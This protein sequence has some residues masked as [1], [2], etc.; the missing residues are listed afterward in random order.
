MTTPLIIVT[1]STRLSIILLVIVSLGCAGEAQTRRKSPQASP[2]PTPTPNQLLDELTRPDP[3][4]QFTET[5]QRIAAL[6]ALGVEGSEIE[7]V[8]LTFEDLDGDGT[9]EALFTIQLDLANDIRL[10]VLK[11]KGNQWYRLASPEGFSCWCKYE[12]APLDTFAEIRG[13]SYGK[14]GPAKLLFVRGSG[15]G[16]GLYDRELY[17]YTLQGFELKEAFHVTEERRECPGY[18]NPIKCDIKHVDVMP[19]D[20]SDQ[21]PALL[22]LSYERK[23]V[24]GDFW[25]DTWW[26][27]L[28]IQDCKSYT[29][30]PQRQQ[31]LENR[32]ATSA[33]C[34]H[35][36]KQP[37]QAT[38]R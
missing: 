26:I 20:D 7:D 18:E 13:W 28:P 27:G 32:T 19:V 22:A 21:P 25:N 6:Q 33:Y 29:W 9:A 23:D 35:L 10:I 24:G 4:S 37:S 15:G 5:E 30:N 14:N 17:V 1:T 38:K 36:G 31:F 11:R 2:Q 8:R 3:R 12:G 34:G 16:T